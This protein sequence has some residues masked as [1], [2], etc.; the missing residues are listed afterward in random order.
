MPNRRTLTLLLLGI[1]LTFG[2]G[3]SQ[4]K[5]SITVNLVEPEIIEQIL[6]PPDFLANIVQNAPPAQFMPQGSG[7]K[8]ATVHLQMPTG[9]SMTIWVYQP[10]PLPQ[11]KVPCVFIAPA[12][13][14]MIH[15]KKL[16]SGDTQE[17]LPWVNA[18]FAV[19][20]Y[21]LS[22]DADPEKSSDVQ[23]KSAVRQFRGAKAGLLN[24]QLAM[25]Y[26][27]DKVSFVDESKFFT[28]GHSSAGTVALYVAEM[29]PQVKGCA[30]FM[31]PVD[32]RQTLGLN[33]M[34]KIQNIKLVEDAGP[35]VSSISPATYI[36]RL[37][38]PTFMFLSKDDRSE[39]TRPAES[40]AR[41]LRE[42]G[43]DVTLIEIERGG[44][45]QPMLQPGIPL[46]IEWAKMVLATD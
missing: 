11:A 40:F 23:L 26:A 20:A 43:K 24:A 27:R 31:P 39:I 6:A 28:A 8:K 36:D 37:S 22:G 42:G 4:E 3:C 2:V 12:G 7:A 19:V 18:G 13:T 5:P 15:G 25:A 38:K 16:A 17:H 21:E 29:E 33:A 9:G 30:A 34:T 32:V 1:G 14:I 45:Y 44:H 41:K 35:F 10:D 46:A